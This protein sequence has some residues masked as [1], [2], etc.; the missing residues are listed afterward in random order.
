MVKAYK[1]KRRNS[2]TFDLPFTTS[3]SFSRPFLIET[4]DLYPLLQDKRIDKK[5]KEKR[6]IY[7]S[8]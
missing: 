1:L 8:Q 2:E 4:N 7:N 6:K 5:E 3:K